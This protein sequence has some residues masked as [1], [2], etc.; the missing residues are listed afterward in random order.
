MNQPKFPNPEEFSNQFSKKVR[1]LTGMDS[2]R[3]KPPYKIPQIPPYERE[4]IDR[5]Y[6]SFGQTQVLVACVLDA[7]LGS[8]QSVFLLSRKDCQSILDSNPNVP[9]RF[10][11]TSNGAKPYAGM[12]RELEQ[13][14]GL[15]KITVAKGTRKPM[16]VEVV[17][18]FLLTY[19]GTSSEDYRR[20]VFKC[21]G[22]IPLDSVLQVSGLQASDSSTQN[23]A[24]SSQ[25]E[26]APESAHETAQENVK[27]NHHE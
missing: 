12:L 5:L 15:I 19:T 4:S 3:L 11:L 26:T 27:G 20:N 17:D 16:V 9:K 1:A 7:I 14:Q 2:Y 25:G 8:N 13:N 10:S 23:S 21:V 24:L 18:P 22:L 6:Y